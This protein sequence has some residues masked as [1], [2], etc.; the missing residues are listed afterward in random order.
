MEILDQITFLFADFFTPKKRVFFGYLLLS[1]FIAFG[2]LIFVK[3]LT[4]K[5]A[6]ARIMDRK[7]FFSNSALADYKIFVINRLF[8]ALIS[9]LL[10]TQVAIA[11]SIFFALHSQDLIPSGYFSDAS[12]TTVVALFTLSLFVIDDFTKYLVHRWMHRFPVLW[13]IHKIHHSATTLTPVTVYRIHPL[14]GVLYA[15]RGTVAQ[16]VAI[17]VFIFLFGSSVDL[18][19]ILGANVLVFI[20]HVTGSN[21]RHSHINIGYWPWLE[22]I[23]ISPAQH[24]LHHSVAE[25]H[26][27]KNF[28]AA[29]AIW[30]W[31]FGS[32]H[33]SQT[34]QDQTLV[35][36]LDASEGTSDTDLRTIYLTPFAE[37]ANVIGGHFR[38]SYRRVEA[39]VTGYRR[40]RSGRPAELETGTTLER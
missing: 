40:S 3:R 38:R 18:Y 19:T 13:A 21:L 34:D 25:E 2:W 5:N 29:L 6:L 32:L 7:V 35:F 4:L 9:P 14:E 11:T 16:G 26:F 30:D 36:G 10:L 8:S 22:R 17:S 12:K 24:Q 37:I 33:L 23:F 15:L 39:I 28:G 1:L 31:L 20:F 27:D